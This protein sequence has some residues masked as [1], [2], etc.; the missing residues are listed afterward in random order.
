MHIHK[1]IQSHIIIIIIII[2][3]HQHVSVTPVTIIRVSCNKHTLNI[4][5]TVQKVWH[6]DLLLISSSGVITHTSYVLEDNINIFT[7][8]YLLI[9]HISMKLIYMTLL[10][11]GVSKYIQ[12]F[13]QKTYRK[14]NARDTEE[15]V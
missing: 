8:V 3:I 15:R 11:K 13:N 10:M 12:S 6:H 2:I 7:N 9:N 14:H 5:I 1:C 4:Q